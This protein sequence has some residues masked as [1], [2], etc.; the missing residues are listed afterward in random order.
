MD[1]YNGI[2]SYDFVFVA[3]SELDNLPFWKAKVLLKTNYANQQLS[4]PNSLVGNVGVKVQ[5]L[6]VEDKE[7]NKTLKNATLVGGI[8]NDPLPCIGR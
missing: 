3:E 5:R 1:N 7:T 8:P 4:T 2:E 6:S